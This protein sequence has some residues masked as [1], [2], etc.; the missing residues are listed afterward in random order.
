[1]SPTSQ[2]VVRDLTLEYRVRTTRRLVPNIRRRGEAATNKGIGGNLLL[3]GDRQAIRSLDKVSFALNAGDRVALLGKNGAG[4]TSLLSVLAGVYPPTSGTVQ[5]TGSVDA[6]F[7]INLGFRQDATGRRN[8]IL[9]GLIAGWSTEQI[10]DRIPE[11]IEFSELGHFIDMPYRSYSQGMA[12]R[13]A[14]SIATAVS[15][16]VLLLDEWIGAGDADF[17]KKARDRMN[18]LI[19]SAG[20]L[21][22]ASHNKALLKEVCNKGMIL[23]RGEIVAEGPIGEILAK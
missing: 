23:S 19:E 7:N 16:D 9:R 13:L 21:V 4:K 1:M 18:R 20:I 15:P 14:F 12:A 6:L 3:R 2:I 22:I 10:K 11:I 8:I 5:I 17:Q